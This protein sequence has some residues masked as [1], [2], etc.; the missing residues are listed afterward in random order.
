MRKYLFAVLIT[1]LCLP[2]LAQK[3][4]PSLKKMKLTGISGSA[5]ITFDKYNTM[6]LDQLTQIA[7]QP[8]LMRRDLDGL[9]EEASTQTAGASLFVNMT[10]SPHQKSKG[11][12]LDNLEFRL[13][14][15]LNS[16]KES[17]VSYKNADMDTSLVFCNVNS[18]LILETSYIFKHSFGKRMFLYFGVGANSSFSVN[19][20][21]MIISGK[22]F[23]EGEHPS[24]QEQ[25]GAIT[26]EAK[27]ILYSRVFVP[28]GIHM[29][30]SDRVSF[31]L[32]FRKGRGLQYTVGEKVNK[33]ANTG[34]VMIGTRISFL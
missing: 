13:G 3:N 20:E 4:T 30:A 32:D 16:A 23:S 5:G 7:R 24:A 14:V 11:T 19:N 21:M 27:P 12:Y 29:Q 8:E 33:I 9:T 1:G 34:A 31:G 22:Y 2:V 17:M 28:W 18:E 26:F 15:G 10:F 6:S 25:A